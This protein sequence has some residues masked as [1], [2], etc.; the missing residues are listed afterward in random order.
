ML[1]GWRVTEALRHRA[2]NDPKRVREGWEP[3][4]LL[5]SERRV[6]GA[7][8]R[9]ELHRLQAGPLP[10]VRALADKLCC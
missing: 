1:L 9:G 2:A 3:R 10:P 8:R 4:V 7:E 6:D 5:A